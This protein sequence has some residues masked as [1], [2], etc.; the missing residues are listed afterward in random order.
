MT[1]SKNVMKVSY[2]E[3]ARYLAP[4]PPPSEWPVPPG[5]YDPDAGQ[6]AYQGMVQRLER[7]EEIGFDWISV[8]EHH[9]S[10]IRE[11]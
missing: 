3:T 4:Q 10:R 5:A 11:A 9:Y 2:F 7:V 6:Q 1:G 8:S